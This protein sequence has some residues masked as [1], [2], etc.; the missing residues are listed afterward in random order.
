MIILLIVLIL[1]L[2]LFALSYVLFYLGAVR[3]TIG[4]KPSKSP[5][6]APYIDQFKAGADWFRSQDPQRV[7]IRSRDGLKL[8]GY[9]LP[10][11]GEARGTLLMA[12]GYRSSLW[13]DFAIVYRY[14]HEM[15]WNILAIHERSH[16]ESE[17][18]YITFGIKERFDV[19]DWAIYLTDRF[20]PSHTVILDGISMGAGTVL[21]ALGT[22]LPENVK[23][24]IVDCGYTC[25]Y[26]LYVHVLKS[27][28]VPLCRLLLAIAQLH[29]RAFAGF[30][31]RD[32]S[33]ITA[34]KQNHRPVLFIHGE[35]DSLVPIR[36][37]MENYAACAGSKQLITVPG[38]GHAM[39][40]LVQPERCR[41]ALEGFLAQF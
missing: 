4:P 11:E 37:T 14:Y 28:H 23:G 12:H 29:A 16:G 5:I 19:C 30:G 2:L 1:V 32:Y 26:D 8:V 25:P 35:A 21:M 36:F 6:Y 13:T 22:E 38:A 34:L 40:Y 3:N 31:F 41:A 17:G 27:H 7:S 20:G 18:R 24:A 15:G 39:S 33:A 10:A 9:F